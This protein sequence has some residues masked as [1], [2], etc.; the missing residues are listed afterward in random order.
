M[1]DSRRDIRND[2]WNTTELTYRGSYY[3]SQSEGSQEA[4][5]GKAESKDTL[6]KLPLK[7]RM[8]QSMLLLV[9]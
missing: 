7:D 5:T 6:R 3:L 8:P 1:M 9:W 2:S 4:I